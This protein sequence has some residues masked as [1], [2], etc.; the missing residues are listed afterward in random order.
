M[1]RRWQASA[2]A[3]ERRRKELWR[4]YE[5]S[6]LA[7]ILAAQS[8]SEQA[9]LRVSPRLARASA[10]PDP[11]QR[12]DPVFAG[13]PGDQRVRVSVSRQRLEQPR[14]AGDVADAAAAASRRRSPSRGR[15]GPRPAGR[16][17]GRDGGSTGSQPHLGRLPAV[18]ARRNTVAKFS[19]TMPSDAAMTSSW[20]VGQVARRRG[21][22]M[23]VGMGGDQ[24]R[25]GQ[26]GHVV[27]ALLVEVAR[28]RS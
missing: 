5:A 16:S 25:V 17:G 12:G 11:F 1:W 13:D 21:D 23:G 4:T 3:Q 18:G 9:R 7:A 8:R 22:G 20:P 10:A 24:R 2:E 15:R 14:Q 26:R 6:D 28:G 19:P 27:E